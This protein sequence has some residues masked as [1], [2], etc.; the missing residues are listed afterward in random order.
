MGVSKNYA[1][2]DVI[3]KFL[4]KSETCSVFSNK[5]CQNPMVEIEIDQSSGVGKLTCVWQ[6]DYLPNACS[7]YECSIFA[8]PRTNL[9]LRPSRRILLTLLSRKR[10]VK[11]TPRSPICDMI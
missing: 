3:S 10:L 11:S 7:I 1:P 5:V 9:K 8:I 6:V 2:I 4:L